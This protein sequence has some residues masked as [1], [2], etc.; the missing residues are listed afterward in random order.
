[1]FDNSVIWLVFRS[2]AS[3]GVMSKKDKGAIAFLRD[4]IYLVVPGQ[5]AIDVY[6]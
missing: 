1:M 6:A 4:S 2:W 5:F 3:A